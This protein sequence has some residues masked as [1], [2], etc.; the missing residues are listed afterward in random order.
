MPDTAIDYAALDR[1]VRLH[2]IQVDHVPTE[3]AGRPA[4]KITA[5]PLDKLWRRDSIDGRQWDAG[6]RLR[7]DYRDALGPSGGQKF[8]EPGGGG[9][10]NAPQQRQIEASERLAQAKRAVGRR[11]WAWLS[12]VV[13]DAV[14]V[15]DTARQLGAANEQRGMGALLLSLDA[16]ADHYRVLS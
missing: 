14:T 2:G 9:A 5:D 12:A 16:L 15:A 3:E 11:S 6:D 13:L 1:R 7:R 10:G 8:G 4:V